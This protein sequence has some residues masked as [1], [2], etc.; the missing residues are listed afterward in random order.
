MRNLKKIVTRLPLAGLLALLIACNNSSQK[1]TTN[2]KDTIAAKGSYAYDAEFLKAHTGKIIELS[3]GQGAKVLLSADYQ[4]R[5]MTS[6]ATGDT[7]ISFGWLKYDLIK[8]KEKKAQFNPVG[9]EERFWLGPEG[10]QY[11]L[12]F[13]PGDSFNIAKWQVPAIIDT[14]V[15]TVAEADG[16]KATFTQKAGLKNY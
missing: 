14:V 16:S 5:V 2:V 12:Y 3:N 4:G 7:G 10:G 6:T 15:Y 13:K 11:S 8:A 9:G 1:Q